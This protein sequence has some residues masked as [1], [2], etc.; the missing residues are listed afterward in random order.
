MNRYAI[1]ALAIAL[2]FVIS[3]QS[4]I[5][6]QQ[7]MSVSEFINSYNALLAGKTLITEIV[8]DGST[9]TKI[10]QYGQAKKLENGNYEIPVEVVI[11]ISK[12]GKLDQRYTLKILDKVIDH[13]G[14]AIVADEVVE[15]KIEKSGL[16]PIVSDDEEFNGHYIVTKNDKG[17]FDAWSFSLIPS[18]VSDDKLT[19][20]NLGG[21]MIH[22]SCY[23]ENGLTNCVLT[24]RDYMLDDY[25][26]MVGFKKMNPH[27]G[28]L[29]EVSKEIK[30]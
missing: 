1:F 24:I 19:D 11:N 14:V 20:L 9:I 2:I 3:I 28:D 6:K 30:N 16:E 21:S 17:G 23:P 12:E 7:K 29:K 8:E 4:S 13:G 26:P 5:A 27:G 10:R 25:E 15:T 22:Y 18:I